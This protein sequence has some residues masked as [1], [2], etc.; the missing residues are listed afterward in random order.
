[1]NPYL[2]VA[3]NRRKNLIRQLRKMLGNYDDAEDMYQ[4]LLVK[5]AETPHPEPKSDKYILVYIDQKVRWMV[6]DWYKLKKPKFSID[7][8]DNIDDIQFN[9]AWLSSHQV[10]AI[11][12]PADILEKEE[13]TEELAALIDD[14]LNPIHREMLHSV[15]FDGASPKSVAAAYNVSADAVRMMV[16]RFKRG[17]LNGVVRGHRS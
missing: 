9:P 4:D 5:M 12:D 8:P 14:V 1:M 6:M 13:P 3:M 11:T 16:G 7:A 17:R 10:R 15:I 2:E